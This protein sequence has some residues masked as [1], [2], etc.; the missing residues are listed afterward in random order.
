MPVAGSFSGWLVEQTPGTAP[1]APA[2]VSLAD[3]AAFAT[4]TN[5]EEVEGIFWDAGLSFHRTAE[6]SNVV[7]LDSVGDV[8]TALAGQEPAQ[9]GHADAYDAT[10][11]ASNT[12]QLFVGGDRALF[13]MD[14]ELVVAFAVPDEWAAADVSAGAAWFG[15]DFAAG[16]VTE[17][18]DFRVWELLETWCQATDPSDE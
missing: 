5:P 7:I 8:Y 9:V 2:G 15:Q 17:Y 1:T 11:G 6:T 10:P 14:G 18:Q 4:F 13:G 3:F 12:L 16:R